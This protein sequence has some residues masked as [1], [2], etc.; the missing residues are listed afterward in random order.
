V[1]DPAPRLTRELIGVRISRELKPGMYVN[2]GFG[3][4]TV[5]PNFVPPDAGILFHAENG[6]LG[7]GR[8]AGED[9]MDIDLVNA[10]AE[11]VTLVPGASL[12]SSADAFGMLRGGHIDVAVLGAY[13]VAENGDIANWK[14]AVQPLGGVGGAMDVA[15]G[16]RRLLVALEHTTVTGAPKLLPRCTLPVTAFG[17]VN[18]VVTDLAWLDITPEG[19]LL[20]E[21]APGWTFEAVQARTAARLLRAPD[22]KEM[23]F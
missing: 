1:N 15:N 23:E 9:E 12:F 17:V 3:I 7:Y 6:I 22:V 21:L 19:F 20:R 8:L 5:I 18:S 14:S 10:G 4:P 2:L 13:Q 11:P 16:A